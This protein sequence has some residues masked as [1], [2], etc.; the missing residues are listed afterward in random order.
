M[1]IRQR[2]SI[3]THPQC[4]RARSR[5]LRQDHPHRRALFLHGHDPPPRQRQGRHRAY[6]VSRKKRS[7]TASRCRPRSASPTGMASRSIFSTHR[8][9]LDFTGEAIAATRVA[10]GAVVVLGRH[11]RRR[12]RD[13]ESLGIL[14][15]ARDSQ[16]FFRLHDGQGATRTS[17]RCATRSAAHDAEGVCRPSCRS[18]RASSSAGIVNL[19]TGK[20]HIFKAGTVTGEYD[21]TDI[22]GGAERCKPS[23]AAH[24]AVRS[25]RNDE[26]RAARA[27]PRGRRDLDRGSADRDEDRQCSPASCS[28]SS[29]A[30]PKRRGACAHCSRRS[31]R[32][33]PARPKRRTSSHSVPASTRSSS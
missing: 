4:R 14:R 8:G 19:F 32:S 15:S 30:R 17:T 9:Y 12:G 31:S 7:R 11:D 10:D 3:H 26:R 33:C 24:G 13:R 18:A 5:R 23:C 21:E 28:R 2:I 16:T 29:A 22:P 25:D 1:P 27:L 6:D 20:A